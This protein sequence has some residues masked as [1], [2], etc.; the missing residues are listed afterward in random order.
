MASTKP[1]PANGR[2]SNGHAAAAVAAAPAVRLATVGDIAAFLDAELVGNAETLI[3]GVAGLES[4]VPGAIL[5]V[6][7]EKLLSKAQSSS[8]AAIIVPSS[9]AP[10]VR[11]ALQNG[12]KPLVLTGNPRL[13]FAKVM[14][15]FQP[16]VTPEVGVHPTAVIEAD[17]HIGEGVTIREFCYV[18]HHAH[19]GN[20]TIVYP[21]VVIGDGAQIGDDTILFP[22]VV[23]NHHVH[24]GQRVRIHSGSVL[25][26]DGFGYVM[27]G[28][29]HHKV[30][31]VGTVIIEDDVEIGANVCIDRATIGATRVG[32]GTKI[33][34]MVQIAHNV[35]IGRNCILC[36]QVGLSGS[37]IIE[38]NV[39]IAG[40]VGVKDH[41]K[42]GK[43]AILGAKAGVMTNVEGGNFML[44][45]PAVL[46]RDFM[47]REVSARKLPEALRTLRVM[48]KQLQAL[49]E[50]V[51]SLQKTTAK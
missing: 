24:V 14:E 42:V 17:A 25:G 34:N 13:A 22:S 4:A 21:H 46:Q 38:D 12:S 49:Q 8:A 15:Y 36:A 20:G 18:G 3:T 45:S 32:A 39:V 33:D 48:E 29:V 27:D 26:G 51:D 47:K 2:T 9:V 5:F 31:Q 43:G 50:Q 10:K 41:M 19:I 16:L 7:N 1:Q 35:Q 30:P 23:I 44:G 6:E 28:G 40:Q 37:V 11:R